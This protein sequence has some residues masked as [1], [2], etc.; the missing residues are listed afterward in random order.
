MTSTKAE[1]RNLVIDI[2]SIKEQ[3]I[4]I[5]KQHLNLNHLLVALPTVVEQ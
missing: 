2:F 3:L 5:S 1:K 4:L